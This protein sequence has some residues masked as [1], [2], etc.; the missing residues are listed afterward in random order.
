MNFDEMYAWWNGAAKANPMNAILSD[1]TDWDTAEFFATGR[2]WLDGHCAF[3]EAAGVRLAGQDA[4]DFGCGLGRMSAALS[5]RYNNV[6]GID[7]SDEMIQL[8]RKH[9]AYAAAI[10]FEQVTGLPLPYPTRS[11]DLVYS[12]IVVQHIPLP[13]NVGYVDEF[14][15]VSRDAVLFDAPSHKLR[16]SDPEPIDGIFLLPREI[17]L[18]RA[19]AHGFELAA[20]RVFPATPT[21]Q[22]QYLF[23]RGAD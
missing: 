5:D 17:V 10:K 4:L 6:V 3:A 22:Y 9:N 7:I 13:Y 18:N 14:F 21:C 8:A 2:A 1:V 16:A 19:S 12:T 23:T 11:F 20:I 15:R